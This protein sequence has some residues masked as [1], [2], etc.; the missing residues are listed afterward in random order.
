MLGALAP[1]S[2]FSKVCPHILH[3]SGGNWLQNTVV[4]VAA[5]TRLAGS[6][7]RSRVPVGTCG[8][9]WVGVTMD[10]SPDTMEPKKVLL[11]VIFRS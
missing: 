8:P 1:A 5:C 9:L 6:Q 3:S 10:Q 2:P 4:I 11:G 7:G